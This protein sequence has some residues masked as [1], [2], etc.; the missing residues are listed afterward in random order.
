MIKTRVLH[1]VS[2]YARDCLPTRVKTDCGLSRYFISNRSLVERRRPLRVSAAY[3][4]EVTC[5]RCR[6]RKL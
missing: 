1:W 5:A 4:S 2:P 3:H 6:K